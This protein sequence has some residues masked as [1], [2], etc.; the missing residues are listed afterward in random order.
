VSDTENPD[1]VWNA[2][3]MDRL[4]YSLELAKT[5]TT[6]SAAEILE[7]GLL[8]RAAL[9][10]FEHVVTFTAV[11]PQPV[12]PIMTKWA[13]R[14]GDYLF[15]ARAILDH[16]MWVAAHD[17]PTE[18]LTPK[19]EKDLQFPICETEQQWKSFAGTA[20]AKKIRQPLLDRIRALQ[21]FT[22]PGHPT[23]RGMMFMQRIHRYDKHRLPLKLS[24][25]LDMQ[26]LPLFG[27]W[28]GSGTY[29][30]EWLEFDEP[31]RDGLPLLR[32][33]FVNRQALPEDERLNVAAMATFEGEDYDLQDLIWDVTAALYRAI[34]GVSIGATLRADVYEGDVAWRREALAA[35]RRSILYGTDEWK[36]RGFNKPSPWSVLIGELN[37][38]EPDLS[39]WVRSEGPPGHQL[40]QPLVP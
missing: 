22:R 7:V 1:F 34:D 35:L 20:V 17:N 31:I 29:E 15:N 5:L 32:R 14:L 38:P 26:M 30:D 9:S 28:A 40:G 2:D 36:R 3:A 13:F 16:V 21:P 6:D 27:A 33:R 39:A 37:K 8:S 11:V 10:G 19:D 12:E 18:P 24:L 4:G 25:K 23:S